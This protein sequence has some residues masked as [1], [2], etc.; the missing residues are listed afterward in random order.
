MAFR[1]FRLFRSG[2]GQGRI[3]GDN[4]A[5]VGLAGPE[6]PA[7]PERVT[8]VTPGLELVGGRVRASVS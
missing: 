3:P 6:H 2:R 5:L 1:P 8:R 4:A 7:Q